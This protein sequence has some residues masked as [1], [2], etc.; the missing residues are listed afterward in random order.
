MRI[1][2]AILVLLVFGCVAKNSASDSCEKIYFG[3]EIS[4]ESLYKKA[5]SIPY[6]NFQGNMKTYYNLHKLNQTKKIYKDKF[7]EYKQ[8][9]ISSGSDVDG[10]IYLT[11]EGYGGSARLTPYPGYVGENI[12]NIESGLLLKAY[13]YRVI[14]MSMGDA[15]FYEVDYCGKR[16]WIPETLTD[17]VPTGG[18]EGRRF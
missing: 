3:Q 9:F 10:F 12:K 4:E 7:D 15:L 8:L 18:I 14:E 2:I 16:Y 1:L 5:R 11:T 13:N 6:I 17:T